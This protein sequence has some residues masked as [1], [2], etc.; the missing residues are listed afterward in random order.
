[1]NV[2]YL[3]L[4][5]AMLSFTGCDQMQSALNTPGSSSPAAPTGDVIATVNGAPITQ[6]VLDVYNRQRAAKGVQSDTGSPD[7]ALNEL[8]AL[9]LM[10]QEAVSSGADADPVISATLNQLE[11]ST[12]AGAAIKAFMTNSEVS[13]AEVREMY[14]TNIGKPGTEYYARHILVETEEEANEVIKLLE[15]DGDFAEL[16]KEKSTGPSGP[17]GGVLGWFSSGQMVKPFSDAT[18]ALE[19]GSYTRE[20][21]KTQFGWHVIRLE[22]T[23]EGTPPPFDDVKDR[24]KMMIT[25]Q[26]LQQHVEQVRNSATIDIK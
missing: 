18:A 20:P 4:A 9:E 11:R 6:Q 13:D 3:L 8:I 24:L 26:K 25:N 16:A 17:Q 7:A 5:A 15:A 19:K 12:L 23:R 21:V 2:R 10:R 22:D 14:D 1:M